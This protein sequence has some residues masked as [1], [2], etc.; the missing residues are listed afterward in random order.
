EVRGQGLMVGV[1]FAPA[2]RGLAT[3]VTGG[4]ANRLSRRFLAGLVV[5]RLITRHRIVTAIALNNHNVLRLEP[6]LAVEQSHL[7]RVVESLAETLET[8]ASFA[9][10]AR[11]SLPDLVRA[12][13]L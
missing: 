3:V 7:D 10:A 8:M 13:R 2:T 6:P 9:A 5:K 4:V 12:L 1:E 11:R